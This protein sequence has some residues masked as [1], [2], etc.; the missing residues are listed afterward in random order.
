MDNLMDVDVEEAEDAAME[1]T[2]KELVEPNPE[3]R[4]DHLE[5]R[6]GADMATVVGDEG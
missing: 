2:K 4:D 6:A 3:R 1:A 5:L